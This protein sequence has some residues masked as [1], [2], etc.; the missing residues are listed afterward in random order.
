VASGRLTSPPVTIGLEIHVRLRTATKLFCPC[1][2]E[3]DAPPNTRICPVCMGLPGALPVLADRAVDL[4]VRAALGLGAQVARR[5]VFARKH[6]F[7]PDLP[8]NYQI[9]QHS[10]PLARGGGFAAG[11]V[12]VRIRRLHLEEDAGRSRHR[13]GG[14]TAVDLNRAG[15]PLVEIVTE[16]DLRSGE[17]ARAWL[18]ELRRRLVFLGV[19]DGRMQDGSLRCDAN[20]GFAD[21]GV[22]TELKNLNSFRA[23]AR[24]V[25]HEAARLRRLAAGT[26][27]LVRT[28][29]AWDEGAGRTHLLRTKETVPDYRYL[30]EPD[31]PALLVAGRRLERL[32]AA[33]PPG[34]GQREQELRARG[35]AA[36]AAA[37]L[38]REPWLAAY[39]TDVLDRLQAGAGPA[40]AAR[41]AALAASWI[42]TEVLRDV[43]DPE[44]APPAVAPGPLAGLLGLLAA[45]DITRPVAK[46]I[47]ARLQAGDPRS[48][49]RIVAEE[50]LEPLADPVAIRQLCRTALAAHPAEAAALRAGRV[51]LR[52][53]F[54]GQVLQLSGGRARPEVVGRELAAV[55]AAG[56]EPP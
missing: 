15:T 45:G 16:P 20:V 42:R 21:V 35:V 1:A 44:A 30:E 43:P 7:Y 23:V 37:E 55:L 49:R 19:T 18:K 4:A 9:T 26:A 3:A 8:R 56:A 48:P 40:A 13:R 36:A 5:S 22:L 33:L 51:R 38:C 29:R 6:Y 27:A 17:T 46:A 52:E 54:V 41:L 12:A 2:N 14:P 47:H 53:F 11:G 25:D 39:A 10:R 28:T 34:P 31:L 32:A 24:A 50:R